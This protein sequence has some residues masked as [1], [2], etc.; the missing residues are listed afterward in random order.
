MENF[1]KNWLAILLIVF[2]FFALGFLFGW[3]C[4]S[5]HGKHEMFKKEMM[6][7]N[8]HNGCMQNMTNCCTDMGNARFEKH[9]CRGKSDSLKIIDVQVQVE[10]ED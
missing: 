7:G 8:P 3:T 10:D 5:C 6:M 9:I 1:N 4:S 2:V